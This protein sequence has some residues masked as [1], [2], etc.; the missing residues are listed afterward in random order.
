MSYQGKVVINGSEYCPFA[1]IQRVSE[2]AT[3]QLAITSETNTYHHGP[4]FVRECHLCAAAAA[5][6]YLPQFLF[7]D[8]R[9][10]SPPTAH[11]TKHS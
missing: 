3:E 9:L 7:R 2:R 8:S 11:S 6:H 10:L 5:R 4:G 1:D